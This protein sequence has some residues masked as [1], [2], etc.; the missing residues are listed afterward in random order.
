QEAHRTVVVDVALEAGRPLDRRRHVRLPHQPGHQPFARRVI[1]L[2]PR[3]VPRAQRHRELGFG[4]AHRRESRLEE[5]ADL[6]DQTLLV[7]L[8]RAALGEHLL[9]EGVEPALDDVPEGAALAVLGPQVLHRAPVDRLEPVQR[10]LALRDLHLGR[11]ELIALRAALQPAREE[12]LARTVLAAHRLEGPVA[13]RDVAALL[14]ERL[15]EPVETDREVLEAARRDRAGAQ[16]GHDLL[17]QGLGN[18]GRIVEH[19]SFLVSTPK[20]RSKRSTSS[21]TE[22]VARSS[23]RQVSPSALR[24]DR[25]RATSPPA[26]PRAMSTAWAIARIDARPPPSTSTRHTASVCSVRRSRSLGATGA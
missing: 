17:T 16:G 8:A 1:P 18:L 19:H 14:V 23:V 9:L 24:T 26:R 11:R 4:R 15:G 21:T 2:Q 3:T 20:S 12:R 6:G 22:S 7:V 10:R 5:L 25:T 13:E